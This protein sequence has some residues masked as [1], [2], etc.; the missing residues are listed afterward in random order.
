[1]RN[2]VCVRPGWVGPYEAVI[3]N[4]DLTLIMMGSYEK[5]LCKEMTQ[6][7]LSCGC[8]V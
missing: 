5:I 3:R 1:M 8:T 2:G 4:L 6:S 7:D